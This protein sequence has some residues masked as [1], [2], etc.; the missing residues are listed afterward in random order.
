M[1]EIYIIRH[2]ET[3]FNNKGIVQGR[4]VDTSLNEKG[5]EQAKQF[6]NKY[7]DAGFEKIYVSNLRRTLETVNPF[8]VKKLSIHKH[9]GLDEISWGIHEGKTNGETFHQFHTIIHAWKNGDVHRKIE[10]GE[11]PLEVQTRQQEFINE[12]VNTAE[13]KLLV[14][15]HGRAMRILLCTLLN[16]PLYMMDT[17]PHENV[18]LYKLNYTNGVFQIEKFND[19]SHFGK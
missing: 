14:C 1:K 11:S 3:E 10:N 7:K 19:V 6:Y 16:K 2:G 17:F 8:T 4:G 13:R 18:C 12:M 9:H 5:R 15:S